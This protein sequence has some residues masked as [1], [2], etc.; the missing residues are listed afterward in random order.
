MVGQT[1]RGGITSSI[2]GSI[3]RISCQT[4]FDLETSLCTIEP[5]QKAQIIQNALEELGIEVMVWPP[6]SPDLNLIENLWSSKTI[7]E[8]Y[9]ELEHPTH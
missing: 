9:V 4:F 5:L 3:H 2:T 6:H 8:L 7:H 1:Q